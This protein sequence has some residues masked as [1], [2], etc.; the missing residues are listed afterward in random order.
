MESKKD[1]RVENKPYL[2]YTAET[3]AEYI[4]PAG[5][6]EITDN[7]EYD[8]SG[9]AA[10]DVNV[11]GGGGNLYTMQFY[12]GYV[13]HDNWDK[14]NPGDMTIDT[15]ESSWNYLDVKDS[16]GN[17]IFGMVDPEYASLEP[18]GSF[19]LAFPSSISL[20]AD[21]AILSAIGRYTYNNVDYYLLPDDCVTIYED[22]D[23][24]TQTVTLSIPDS[25][26]DSNY[27]VNGGIS[28][29]NIYLLMELDN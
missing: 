17:Y 6:L 29:L 16:N 14:E 23:F 15:D 25:I 26:V 5:T 13:D 27:Q 4:E 22:P 3:D 19:Y 24:Y 8:V 28:N 7:G 12:A 11:S 20:R 18:A 9:Y 10:A 2:V 1:D 21:Y